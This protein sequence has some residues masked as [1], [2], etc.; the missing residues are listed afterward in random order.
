MS[1]GYCAICPVGLVRIENECRCPSGQNLTDGKCV[2]AC[3]PGQILDEFGYCYEC[4]IKEIAVDG[5]CQCREGYEKINGICSFK[6]DF[7]RIQGTDLCAKCALGTQYDP[8][9]GA[10][11]CG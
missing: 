2:E 10:C 1:N 4:P 9:L 7:I 3:L 5:K 8:E 6:C 11:I